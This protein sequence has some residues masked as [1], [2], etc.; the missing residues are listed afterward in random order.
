MKSQPRQQQTITLWGSFGIGALLLVIAIYFDPVGTSP[1]SG[2]ID[3][4]RSGTKWLIG[5]LGVA[6]KDVVQH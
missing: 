5:G 2:V 4:G 6:A 3:L 1:D